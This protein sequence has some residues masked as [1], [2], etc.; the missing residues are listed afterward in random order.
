MN[1]FICTEDSKQFIEH[2][3]KIAV[4]YYYKQLIIYAAYYSVRLVCLLS[5]LIIWH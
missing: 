1:I 5:E 4:V 3:P 2:L